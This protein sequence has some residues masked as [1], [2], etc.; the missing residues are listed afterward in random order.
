[1]TIKQLLTAIGNFNLTK[2][3]TIPFNILFLCIWA[4]V[5]L[6]MGMYALLNK[7]RYYVAAAMLIA[8]GLTLFNIYR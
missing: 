4:V 6:C 8:I 3:I 2:L 5:A 1:M 7:Y